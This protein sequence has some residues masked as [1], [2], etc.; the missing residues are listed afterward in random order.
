MSLTRPLADNARLEL[1]TGDRVIARGDGEFDVLVAVQEVVDVVL[2]AQQGPAGPAG[3]AGISTDIV[4]TAAITLGGHRIVS[5]N[6]AGQLVYA[7]NSDMG[8]MRSVIGMTLG[9]ALAGEDATVR[10]AGEVEEPSWSW[11]ANQAVYLGKNGLLTQNVPTIADSV[12]L[13]VVGYPITATRLLLTFREPI[14]LN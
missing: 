9:A 13:Q 12:F 5:A 2:A 1:P 14:L 6:A 7:D 8:T 4:R 3:P 10:W 11:T